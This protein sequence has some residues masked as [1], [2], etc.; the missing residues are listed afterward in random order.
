MVGLVGV[1]SRN[2]KNRLNQVSVAYSVVRHLTKEGVQELAASMEQ[3]LAFAD[4]AERP[5]NGDCLKG[6]LSQDSRAR[7]VEGQ[8]AALE[9][10]L[11]ERR[12][13]DSEATQDKI[14]ARQKEF[15]R[16]LSTR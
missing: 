6:Q 7:E 4:T 2:T 15:E 13:R 14:E 9:A 3:E 5:A 11:V 10:L 12:P 8:L 16:A 1:I